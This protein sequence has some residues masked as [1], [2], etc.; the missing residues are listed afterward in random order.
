MGAPEPEVPK[1]PPSVRYRLNVLF[2]ALFMVALTFWFTR[3]LEI[4]VTQILLIG[5]TMTLWALWQLLQSWLE[6]GWD[7]DTKD[8]AKALLGRARGTEYLVFAWILLLVLWFTTSSIYMTFEGGA[9]GE[10]E[11]RVETVGGKRNLFPALTF[12]ASERVAGQPYFLQLQAQPIELR[13][14][15]PRGYLPLQEKLTPGQRL[16]IKLPGSFRK[17]KFH[18]LRLVPGVYFFNNLPDYS[19]Y[20]SV[21]YEITVSRAGAQP[22]VFRDLRK[23]SLYAGAAG[24]DIR[25]LLDKQE[26]GKSLQGLSDLLH[27][28]KV[29][30]AALPAMLP[31]LEANPAVLGTF[32]FAEGDRVTIQVSRRKSGGSKV[33]ATRTVELG[34]SDEAI[35]PILLE[36]PEEGQS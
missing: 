19:E 34:A 32:E 25:W 24:D 12:N 17:K 4:Y 16:D 1:K 9:P 11:Y 18:V 5:G 33:L 20:P 36:I 2:F 22:V 6:W 3:H 23:Q 35:R 15:E 7:S 13:I 21:F 27:D 28:E 14:V 29:A 26:K 30:P 31:A 8:T 10:S